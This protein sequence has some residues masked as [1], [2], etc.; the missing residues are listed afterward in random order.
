MRRESEADVQREALSPLRQ[1]EGS[2][3]EARA[4]RN[5]L[6]LALALRLSLDQRP[7]DDRRSALCH[8]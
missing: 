6:A 4:C 3:H 5:P 2:N 7:A 8:H 1:S